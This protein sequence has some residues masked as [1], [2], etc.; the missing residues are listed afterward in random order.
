[1]IICKNCK[2]FATPKKIKYNR[3]TAEL[4]ELEIKPCK[5]CGSK[6]GDWDDGEEI[7]R[8]FDLDI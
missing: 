4:K 2:A 8:I 7:A 6:I 5:R 1:M 3:W